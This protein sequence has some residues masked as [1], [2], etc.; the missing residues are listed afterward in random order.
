VR[1]E[2]TASDCREIVEE[3][4]DILT[5]RSAA[6]CVLKTVIEWAVRWIAGVVREKFQASPASEWRDGPRDLTK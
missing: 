1:E 6:N 3:A 4:E 5:G 2:N